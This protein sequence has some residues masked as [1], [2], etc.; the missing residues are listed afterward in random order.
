MKTSLTSGSRD[1]D[2]VC[3]ELSIEDT[4]RL[5]DVLAFHNRRLTRG[6]GSDLADRLGIELR[7]RLGEHA[8]N[9]PAVD[10]QGAHLKWEGQA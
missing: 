1:G 4:A 10:G 8:L 6:I 2:V 3:I 9:G 7:K 5:E